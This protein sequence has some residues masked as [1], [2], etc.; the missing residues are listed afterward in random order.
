MASK[1]ATGPTSPQIMGMELDPHEK[2]RLTGLMEKAAQIK[3]HLGRK[4]TKTKPRMGLLGDL[5]ECMDALIEFQVDQGL[6]GMSYGEIELVSRVQEG[7]KT[8]D[9]TRLRELLLSKCGIPLDILDEIFKLATKTGEP[10]TVSELKVP[11]LD[12]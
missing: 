1:K 2:D 4:E 10:F 12:D 8:L 9:G 6:P 11:G 3:K 5:E 7:R